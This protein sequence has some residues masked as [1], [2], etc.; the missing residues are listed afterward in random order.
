MNSAVSDGWTWSL[1]E[2]KSEEILALNPRGQVPTFKDGDAVVN[3]SLAILLYLEDAYPEKS[4]MPKD[5]KHRA[6]V[7]PSFVIA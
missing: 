2:H 3:E 6:L 1:G 4:L 7:S 5:K